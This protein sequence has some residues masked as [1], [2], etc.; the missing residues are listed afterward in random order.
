MDE[1]LSHDH[2][3]IDILLTVALRK[4]DAGD[5]D[6]F[7]SLDLFW[8]RLAMHVRAE[9][10]HL[11]PAVIR[12]SEAK[13]LSYVPEVLERLRCDHD[14][15]MHELAEIM[16]AM[17]SITPENER[18]TRNDAARRVNAIKDLLTEHNAIE[19]EQIYKLGTIFSEQD[20]G[21][22]SSSV[23]KELENLPP[24]FSK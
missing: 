2:T 19:E 16:K 9:H 1:L 15:F 6:A 13:K 24:R 10:L 5:A 4:L 17:R 11:F 22:L 7:R 14:F 21:A 23:A 8:A 12:I 18:V 20:G 3:E